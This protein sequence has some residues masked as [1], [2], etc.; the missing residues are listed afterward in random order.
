MV[1]A[2][3][4]KRKLPALLCNGDTSRR[5]FNNDFMRNRYRLQ[6][7]RRHKPGRYNILTNELLKVLDKIDHELN[8]GSRFTTSISGGEK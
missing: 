7:L 8:N 2:D 4:V 1:N 6:Q 3:R 5:E